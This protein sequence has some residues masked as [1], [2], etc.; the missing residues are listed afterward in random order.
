MKYALVYLA[1]VA[2]GVLLLPHATTAQ[3]TCSDPDNCDQELFDGATGLSE[4]DY[5]PD[6]SM[7]YGTSTTELDYNTGLYYDPY[8]RGTLFDDATNTTLDSGDAYGSGDT[9]DAEVDTKTPAQDGEVYDLASD[10]YLASAIGGNGGGG[11]GVIAGC[12][13]SYTPDPFYL[14]ADFYDPSEF[15]ASYPFYGNFQYSNPGCS[16][17]YYDPFGYGSLDG[18]LDYGFGSDFFG[19]QYLPGNTPTYGPALISLGSTETYNAA[20]AAH[21]LRDTNTDITDQTTNVVVGEDVNLTGQVQPADTPAYNFSWFITPYSQPYPPA[22]D[23]PPHWIADWKADTSTSTIVYVAKTPTAA[24][25]SSLTS[26]NVEFHWVDGGDNREVDFSFLYKAK[27]FTGSTIFNVKRPLA[28]LTAKYGDVAVHPEGDDWLL[29]LG[30]PLAGSNGITF[31]GAVDPAFS[32]NTEW[33]QIVLDTKGTR[34]L[35]DGTTMES[36]E[37]SGLDPTRDPNTGLPIAYYY[38]IA[39][40][41]PNDSPGQQLEMVTRGYLSYTNSDSFDMFLMF[42]PNTPKAIWVPLCHLAWSWSGAAVR[43]SPS[44]TTWSLVPNSGKHGDT[45]T[46]SDI[47]IYPSWTQT[48]EA[49]WK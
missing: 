41:N 45:V 2:I 20:I 6:A 22:A 47:A 34:L 48:A 18:S 31:A 11:L 10:H 46:G 35:N 5:D 29:E 3:A 26:Q 21:I 13:P 8:V 27:G 40:M 19:Y 43:T 1:L 32:G 30:N 25:P 49:D 33:V 23:Q 14:E 17:D 24:N 37:S 16:T 39:H 9:F 12:D 38:D 36:F 15:D 7:I 42:K 28:S 4:V 44:A